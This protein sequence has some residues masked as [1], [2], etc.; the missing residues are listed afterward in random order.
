MITILL[1]IYLLM[2][3]GHENVGPKNVH[4]HVI[5]GDMLLTYLYTVQCMYLIVCIEA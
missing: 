3:I 2:H 5:L 4:V 1:T